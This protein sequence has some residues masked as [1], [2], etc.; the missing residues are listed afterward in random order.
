[1]RD[2]HCMIRCVLSPY[3]I[4]PDLFLSYHYRC[5]YLI[6]DPLRL[7]DVANQTYQTRTK[8]LY[9]SR[10]VSVYSVYT[11]NIFNGVYTEQGKV[12]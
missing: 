1:M 10:N 9:I 6:L 11:S 7:I 4:V 8:G 5:R 2:P 3:A 12:D